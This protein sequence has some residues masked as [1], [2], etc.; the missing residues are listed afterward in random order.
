MRFA[1]NISTKRQ[2]DAQR[3]SFSLEIMFTTAEAAAET[4]AEAAAEAS[5][6]AAAAKSFKRGRAS[7]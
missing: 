3:E 2:H 6:E 5:A 7:A 1:S 4:P